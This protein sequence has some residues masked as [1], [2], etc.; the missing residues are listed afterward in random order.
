MQEIRILALDVGEKRIGLAVSDPLGITSQGIGVLI[1]KDPASDLARLLELAREYRVQEIVVGLP[2]HMD[3]RPG[4]AT[5]EILDLAKTLE[6]ALGV[7]VI[8]WDER[9]TTAEAERLMVEADVRRKD[10]RARRDAVAAALILQ[11]V[12]DRRRSARAEGEET[13]GGDA[14]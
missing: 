4:K 14:T 12:L 13:T 5:G 7:K 11:R 6:E 9:L 2:R 1:R 3:G 10:R 8:T